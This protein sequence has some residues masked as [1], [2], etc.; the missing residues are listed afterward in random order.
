MHRVHPYPPLFGPG[1]QGYRGLT[2]SDKSQMKPSEL[3]VIGD[4]HLQA[5]RLL[6]L[7]YSKFHLREMFCWFCGF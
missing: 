5:V 4:E 2:T 1:Q 3:S 6:Y 7:E